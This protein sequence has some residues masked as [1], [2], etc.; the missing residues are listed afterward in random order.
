MLL[1][2]AAWADALWIVC[3]CVCVCMRDR[4]ID[5]ET[6]SERIPNDNKDERG[7]SVV[8]GHPCKLDL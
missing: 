8:S 2:A 5:K 4:E 7:S 6:E 1:Q 3:L